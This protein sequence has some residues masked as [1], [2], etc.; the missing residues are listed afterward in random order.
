L[1][2]V[3]LLLV[4]VVLLI[5]IIKKVVR[6]LFVRGDMAGKSSSVVLNYNVGVGT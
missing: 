4:P 1:S 3:I 2:L 5:I 6:Q